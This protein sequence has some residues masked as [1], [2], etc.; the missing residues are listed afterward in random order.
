MGQEAAQMGER[1][2]RVNAIARHF[3]VDY[4]TADMAL[5]WYRQR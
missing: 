1:G 4:H 5:M 3:G 2:V